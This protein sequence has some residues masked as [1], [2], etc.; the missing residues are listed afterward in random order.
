MPR[1]NY[2]IA[3]HGIRRSGSDLWTIPTG[4]KVHFLSYDDR[5]VS[6]GTLA[7]ATREI[8][9]HSE[10]TPY[11]VVKTITGNGT[12]QSKDYEVYPFSNDEKAIINNI[13][14]A[15][16]AFA[17]FIYSPVPGPTYFSDYVRTL[18]VNR[19]THVYLLACR[20]E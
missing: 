10:K 14:G 17:G 16:G 1:D 8:T 3:G 13:I 2:A 18:P 7:D 20:G 15:G 4:I 19:D 9:E 6:F 11:Q 12:A 5:S